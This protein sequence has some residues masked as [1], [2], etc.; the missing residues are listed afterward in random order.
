MT[1]L[2]LITGCSNIPEYA[3]C[4]QVNVDGPL[5]KLVFRYVDAYG[6]TVKRE[7]SDP[8]QTYGLDL[9]RDVEVK[10]LAYAFDDNLDS[11]ISIGTI[12][13]PIVEATYTGSITYEY[14][15]VYDY[16]SQRDY[17]GIRIN[18]TL[19]SPPTNINTGVLRI[20]FSGGTFG[21]NDFYVNLNY[22]AL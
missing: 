6:V 10:V 18:G 2:F 16:D 11:E 15:E 12:Y 20:F 21:D 14:K 17:C 1:G 3:P 8:S 4:S 22:P 5:Y 19:G 7:F 13:V 9:P